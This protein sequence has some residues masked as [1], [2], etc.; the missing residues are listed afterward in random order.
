MQLFPSSD[1]IE[2]RGLP[3]AILAVATGGALGATLRWAI[4]TMFVG[5]AGAWP[6]PTLV[7]NVLGCLAIGAAANRFERGS[8]RWD[9]IVTGLLGGF[10]TMSSFAVELNDFVDLE[11]TG[12]A[13]AYGAATLACG[14]AAVA[15]GQAVVPARPTRESDAS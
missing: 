10:T 5:E 14:A 13:V 12:V 9:G 15:L 7:V 2:G 3:R 11:R 8:L 1:Q 4:G 6:W